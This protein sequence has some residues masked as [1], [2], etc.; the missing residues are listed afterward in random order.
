MFTVYIYLPDTAADWE[1]GYIAAELGSKRFFK[2]D[3]PEVTLS[4]V[5]PTKDPVKTMGGITVLPDDTVE[6][7]EISDKTVLLL[8]GGN[9][10]DD[11][12]NSAVIG[13]ASELLSAGGT[14]G[15]ICGA[16]TALANAGLLDSR[17]HTSNGAGFL[18]MFCPDYK[19]K[20]FFVDAPAVSDGGLITAAGTGALDW[21]KKIIERLGVFS[22][23]TLDAWYSYYSTGKAE[24]FFALMQSLPS[25]R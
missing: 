20:D 2:E 8:P 23:E 11:P 4:T 14:V 1:A 9:T 13:K 16:T 24:Y 12:K 21:A 22:P 15:A 18:D 25:A 17:P 6:S 10:W 7:I 5:A 3:A 19:G